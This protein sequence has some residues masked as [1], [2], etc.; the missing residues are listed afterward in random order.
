[1]ASNNGNISLL[2]EIFKSIRDEVTSTSSKVAAIA[3]D[4]ATNTEKL[5]SCEQDM[6]RNKDDIGNLYE[7]TG[8]LHG[9]IKEIAEVLKGQKIWIRVCFYGIL[10]ILGALG[11]FELIKVPKL[12]IP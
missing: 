2:T 10:T 5:R 8:K 6:E 3:A 11:V 9:R 4:T 12:P 7:K 1:M